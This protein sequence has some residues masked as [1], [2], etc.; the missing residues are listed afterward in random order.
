MNVEVKDIVKV[1]Q[2]HATVINI[3][4]HNGEVRNPQKAIK[5]MCNYII[6]IEAKACCY[7]SMQYDLSETGKITPREL[8]CDKPKDRL[9]CL[10]ECNKNIHCTLN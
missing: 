1:C 5:L 10:G 7:L 3:A 2:G 6:D 4:A 9:K 8:A